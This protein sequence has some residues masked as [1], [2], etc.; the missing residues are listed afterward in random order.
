MDPGEAQG[1]K[2]AKQEAAHTRKHSAQLTLTQLSQPADASR[3]TG[4]P[5][6]WDDTRAPLGAAGDQDTEV[7]PTGCAPSIC[8]VWQAVEQCVVEVTAEL[9]EVAPTGCAP[10]IPVG[11]AAGAEWEAGRSA[12]T[13]SHPRLRQPNTTTPPRA[14][15][16]RE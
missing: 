16:S 5:G 8:V 13:G 3:R 10:S 12:P 15:K 11:V 14:H 1:R 6:A 2:A 4:C 7:A 9:V